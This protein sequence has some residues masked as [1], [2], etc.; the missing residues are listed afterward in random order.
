MTTRI[1]GLL[2]SPGIR[3]MSLRKFPEP[4]AALRLWDGSPLPSGRRRRF[5]RV[6]AQQQCLS[7]QRAAV[8]AERRALLPSSQD[9]SLEQG[10]QLMQR[11]GIGLH[12]SGALV[13][14]FFA[15]RACQ[16]RREVGG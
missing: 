11:K 2:R 10:R 16:N 7:P 1:Q 5:L 6:Y 9:A 3:L 4:L 14:A 12:G 8:A 13:R 15:W